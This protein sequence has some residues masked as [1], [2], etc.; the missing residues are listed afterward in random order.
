M[1]TSSR[2]NER[3][4]FAPL[5]LG[6]IAVIMLVA[7][8]TIT[9]NSNQAGPTAD[10]R[11]EP[12]ERL[13]T[14]GELFTVT[15]VV[16]SSLPVNVFSGQL[17]FNKD[18]LVVDKIDYNTSVANVWVE[19]PWYSNGDG[20]INFGGG[21]TRGGGFTGSDQLLSITF[22]SLDI[23]EGVIIL[24]NP[25]ILRYDGLGT[26]SELPESIDAIITVGTASSPNLVARDKSDIRF[27]VA[28]AI[29]T[30]DLNGDG[31]QSIADLSI[32]IIGMVSYQRRF[33]F[34]LDGAVDTKD[35]SILL[36]AR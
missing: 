11:I 29:P 23:G 15:L 7:L 26:P 12:R 21:T 27:L 36:N 20:T 30:T 19:E 6:I 8:I 9:N 25:Q 28:E 2:S 13:V 33:D 22:R 24:T 3:T 10:M 32:F 35:L 17:W 4:V 34:N 1:K 18:I 16:E 5:I 14:P 31:K